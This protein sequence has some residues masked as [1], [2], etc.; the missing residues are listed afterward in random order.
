MGFPPQPHGCV[1]RVVAGASGSGTEETAGCAGIPFGGR[2]W[3]SSP[4][5]CQR[6]SAGLALA[7]V[8]GSPRA[9][10]ALLLIVGF[11]P[12]TGARCSGHLWALLQVLILF[13][14]LLLRALLCSLGSFAGMLVIQGAG[15]RGSA[16][17]ALPPQPE[18]AEGGVGWQRSR[19]VTW[20]HPPSS[21]PPWHSAVTPA[22]SRACSVSRA[23]SEQA[24]AEKS[25]RERGRSGWC[26]GEGGEVTWGLA[27][28][29]GL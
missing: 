20:H 10:P 13:Q 1:S 17:W 23:Q 29:G 12:Y 27:A 18:A 19:C 4:C 9:G 8:M 24:R 21:A 25:C 6:E 15:G 2:R 11:C 5:L 7:R 3:L 22:S 26:C 16:L 14:L 28:G